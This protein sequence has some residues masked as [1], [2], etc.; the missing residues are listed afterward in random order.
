MNGYVSIQPPFT[1]RSFSEMKPTARGTLCATSVGFCFLIKLI[2]AL[3]AGEDY[4][5]HR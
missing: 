4:A 1:V 2:P 5:V 3:G